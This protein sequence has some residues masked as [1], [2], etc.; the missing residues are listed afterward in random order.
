LAAE[1]TPFNTAATSPLLTGTSSTSTAFTAAS[2]A[3]G[4]TGSF[5][6][7]VASSYGLGGTPTILN[8]L[9]NTPVEFFTILN[10]T[11]QETPVLQAGVFEFSGTGAGT[12]L[13]YEAVPEP[14]AYALGVCAMLLL[15]VLKRRSSLGST[16]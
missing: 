15:W 6:T 12:T 1:I 16:I 2:V 7:E 8:N 13:T 5:A 11:T 10:S 14:S 3:N 9:D 4:T